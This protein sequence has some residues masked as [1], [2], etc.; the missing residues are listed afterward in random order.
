MGSLLATIGV[1]IVAYVSTDIDDLIVIS[2]FF[3][4]RKLGR[5]AIV[6]GQFLG[7]A[8][9]F[10][11]AAIAA[12]LA[13]TVPDDIT[14]LLGVVPLALGVRGLLRIRAPDDGEAEE[15][16]EAERRAEAR[17]H[18]QVLAVAAVTIANGGDNLGVY[19]PLFAKDATLLP[20]YAAVFAAMTALW[21]LV[22]YLL[23]A[24]PL[25]SAVVR[26]WG[27]RLVPFVLIGIGLHI[28]W[29]ARHL[30]PF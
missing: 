12:V 3:A 26:R 19:I 10:A 4:D 20:T 27:H 30:L 24:N 5:G 8:T 29:G 23:V 17:T 28:L 13:L 9:L 15:T 18:S 21:C 14:A 22:G 11:A 7:I 2:A 25:G 6:F 1:A 16:T